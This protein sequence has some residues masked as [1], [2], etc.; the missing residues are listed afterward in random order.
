MRV[1]PAT[2]PL[3]IALIV[4]DNG[5]GI[6]RYGVAQVHRAPAGHAEF[7]LS[8]VNGQQLKLVDYT[9]DGES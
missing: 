5:T 2:A 8:T 1:R 9:T 6:F 4:D 3:R 7:S